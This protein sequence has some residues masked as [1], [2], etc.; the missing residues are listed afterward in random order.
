MKVLFFTQ[1]LARTGSEMVLYNIIRNADRGEFRLAVAAGD[2]GELMSR[3]P[4]DI[5]RSLYSLTDTPS[6]LRRAGR[7]A[8]RALRGRAADEWLA[9]FARGYEGY[10]WYINSIV[11]PDVLRQAR[12]FGVEC[13][14]HS[15]EMEHMLWHLQE[16]DVRSVVIYP[17]LIIACSNSS[18]Q[19]LRHLG[20]NHGLEVCYES[21]EVK[22]VASSAGRARA[23]R[24]ELGVSE[25]TFV[26]AMSGSVDPNKNPLAFLEVA[27]EL[28]AKRLDVH[29]VWIGG[30]GKGYRPFVEGAVERLGL[31]G[32][33]S[34]VGA[35]TDDYYD[36]LNAADALVLTS[37]RDS[38]PLVMI[39]AAAL[40]KPIVSFNSG[41][42]REFVRPGMGA[43]ID[44]W[45]AADLAAAMAEVMTGE[46][47]F[48]QRAA[49]ARAEEF[50]AP[51]QVRRWEGIMRAYF[52]PR[53]P[54]A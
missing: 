24:A 22:D 27:R 51:V 19:V 38:F 17:R 28:L 25:Q 13:V 36:Y 35:R 52:G 46:T 1:N 34:L 49:R 45:N 42:V 47:P 37:L 26:W 32:S 6:L 29:F 21:V 4:P 5:P 18:A 20:R 23:V 9:N 39:E 15:H 41:G 43:V 12:K 30:G 11:Q 54:G 16:E 31:G 33:V 2:E 8:A 10:I 53:R 3:L 7:R 50:D 48:D 14:V 44:S 40:G